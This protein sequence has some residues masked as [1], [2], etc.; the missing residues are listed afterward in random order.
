MAAK[1]QYSVH[2]TNKF[3]VFD[4]DNSDEENESKTLKEGK[5]LEINSGH[6]DRSHSN[7]PEKKKIIEIKDQKAT[8]GTKDVSAKKVNAYNDRYSKYPVSSTNEL[9]ESSQ[10][11]SNRESYHLRGNNIRS[12]FPRKRGVGG[13]VGTGYSNTS[14][15]ILSSNNYYR[16][17]RAHDYKMGNDRRNYNSAYNYNKFDH[18]ERMFNEYSDS[19]SKYE[20]TKREAHVESI[21][22]NNEDSTS[23]PKKH[24][25][26]TIDYDLYRKQQE[27][28]LISNKNMMENNDRKTKK[29]ALNSDRS[30]VTTN[31]TNTNKRNDNVD[32]EI[33]A[34][35]PKRKA[36]NVYQYILEEGGRVDRIPGFRRGYR[37][38]KKSDEGNWNNKMEGK[39]K[40]QMDEKLFKKRDPPNIND[41]RAFPSLTSK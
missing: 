35:H 3:S 24:D 38:Y 31:T 12:K 14:T 23:V 40:I 10:G 17:S 28:K 25:S 19:R 2:T 41:T 5:K 29:N 16:G 8:V 7:N 22:K 27:K 13:G 33:K 18:R 30:K 4:T 36:I 32:D 37:S 1:F 39:G 9:H 11:R 21:G 20:N 6:E 34:D 26:V 15:N